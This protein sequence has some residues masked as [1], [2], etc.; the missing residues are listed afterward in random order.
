MS[1]PASPIIRLSGSPSCYLGTGQSAKPALKPQHNPRQAAP[2]VLA[3]CLRLNGNG[4]YP[5][6][7]DAYYMSG[8]GGQTTLIIPSH[9]LVVVRLGHYRGGA[10]GAEGFNNAL[11]VLMEAGP[12]HK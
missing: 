1:S 9:D 10:A 8:A 4:R 2:A 6:P 11:A 5:I 12:K 7:R 3:G